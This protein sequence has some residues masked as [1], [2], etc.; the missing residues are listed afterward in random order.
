MTNQE[1]FEQWHKTHYRGLNY[2]SHNNNSYINARVDLDYDIWKAAKQDS[3]AEIAELKAE[4]EGYNLNYKDVCIDNLKL[5][6]A[7]NSALHYVHTNSVL[8]KI[9]V[10]LLASTPAQNIITDVEIFDK[11]SLQDHDDEVI[12][13]CAVVADK[14]I[15]CIGEE[16]RELKGK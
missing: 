7:L 3:A 14:Y 10:E 12:E 1:K 2:A 8:H 9:I 11:K 13:R 5:R 15:L 4:I 16:I 6:E